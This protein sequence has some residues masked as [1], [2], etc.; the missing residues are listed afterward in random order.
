MAVAPGPSLKIDDN[1]ISAAQACFTQSGLSRVVNLTLLNICVN[2][3]QVA[4][5]NEKLIKFSEDNSISIRVCQKMFIS[6]SDL[7]WEVVR[8]L[9]PLKVID[10]K[11]ILIQ[12]GL[13]DDLAE[14]IAEVRVQIFQTFK[15]YHFVFYY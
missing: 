12:S 14:D 1:I 9:I 5:D 15:I 8:C 4:D 11:G 2:S 7:I 13:S 6:Y 10:L 3:L